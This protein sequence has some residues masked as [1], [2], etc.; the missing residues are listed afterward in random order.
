[1]GAE[2]RVADNQPQKR[3]RLDD[4]SKTQFE[5]YAPVSSSNDYPPQS[6]YKPVLTAFNHETVDHSRSLNDDHYH[7]E[8]RLATFPQEINSTNTFSQHLHPNYRPIAGKTCRHNSSR[9][10]Q[11]DQYDSGAE[12]Q[13]DPS[14][15]LGSASPQTDQNSEWGA[16]VNVQLE[17]KTESC[18]V[19]SHTIRSSSQHLPLYQNETGGD[20]DQFLDAE[21]SS[22]CC[23]GMV[24]LI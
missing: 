7:T 15:P 9:Y 4:S 19:D 11:R 1:M 17:Q 13:A 24:S 18:A 21:S 23:Y 6:L 20:N 5:S 10:L 12:S 14:T 16:V 8:R 3:R 2:F 22:E